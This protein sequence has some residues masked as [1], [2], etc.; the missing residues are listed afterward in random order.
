MNKTMLKT[1]NLK[2]KMVTRNV[3]YFTKELLKEAA[4]N[5]VKWDFNRQLDRDAV[6]AIP[7]NCRYPVELWFTHH[8]RHGEPA[9]KHIRA[10]VAMDAA[11]KGGVAFVDM[12]LDFWERLPKYPVRIRKAVA[13]RQGDSIYGYMP[14]GEP[15]FQE[16]LRKVMEKHKE[17]KL[18]L[19]ARTSL[20]QVF[21]DN[22]AEW[23]YE[24]LERFYVPLAEIDTL[25]PRRMDQRQLEAM[26][27]LG[28]IVE[29]YTRNAIYQEASDIDKPA[30]MVE[31]SKPLIQH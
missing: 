3:K 14:W 26:C 18:S 12:P 28:Q 31:N 9:E 21:K 25:N 30:V 19:D 11:P 23:T 7:D 27:R 24:T 4:R 1:M 2:T 16:H 13:K 10:Q 17:P 8:H 15:A 5:A 22:G 20:A 6:S 29:R